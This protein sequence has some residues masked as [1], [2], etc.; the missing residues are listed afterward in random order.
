IR[1]F[2]VELG[3]IETVLAGHESVSDVCAVV[4]EDVQ[5]DKRLVA[6]VAGREGHSP[7]DEALRH[8]LQGQLPHYMVPSAFVVL[9]KLPLTP[10]GKVNRRALPPPTE[11]HEIGSSEAPGNPL[12]ELLCGIWAEVLHVRE[13]GVGDNFFEMG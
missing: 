3:E 1:G 4:R 7:A 12:E 2:R 6:Y 10:S 5:G 9:P 11:S 8:Y 13:V